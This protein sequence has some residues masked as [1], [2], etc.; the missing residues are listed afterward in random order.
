MKLSLTPRMLE[1][2]YEYLRCTLPFRRW[3]LPDGEKIEFWV[4]ACKGRYGYLE[5]TGEVVRI[6]VSA[7]RV[8][9]T[10]D[11]ITTMAHEMIHLRENC[12]GK[13]PAH[14]RRFQSMADRVCRIHGF[15]RET[16]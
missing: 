3:K 1:A 2:A 15:D 6:A 5:N 9:S 4:T 7:T 16:F 12:L 10:T 14:G 11:L 8:E 13:Q